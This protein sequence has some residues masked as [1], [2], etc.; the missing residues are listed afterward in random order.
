MLSASTSPA[1]EPT[2]E[3]QFFLGPPRPAGLEIENCR[4]DPR[5]ALP[6]ALA[7]RKRG[8]WIF[9][10]LE[11]G[12]GGCAAVVL[13]ENDDGWSRHDLSE[14]KRGG[15]LSG[16]SWHFVG[17]VGDEIWAVLD[18]NVESLGWQLLLV[19]SSDE[20]A[21][22]AGTRIKKV[23]YWAAFE[24]LRMSA[25]GIGRLTIRLDEAYPTEGTTFEPGLYHY[26][27]ANGGRSW[28]EAEWE[29]DD[30][31]PAS[32]DSA[33]RSESSLPKKT[34]QR[35]VEAVPEDIPPP[36]LGRLRTITWEKR[37]R[38]CAAT[39]FVD[40]DVPLDS[41]WRET[42]DGKDL[43]IRLRGL[44][45]EPSFF[46]REVGGTT[47]DEIIV[48]H[49]PWPADVVHLTLVPPDGV[50]LS[51]VVTLDGESSLRLDLSAK[52]GCQH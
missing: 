28:S 43:T 33:W 5:F 50:E 46:V 26:R 18:N 8:A 21:T 51:N 24:H 39:V 37:D 14:A 47:L 20:G 45:V 17:V 52:T 41:R 32:S 6:A 7:P 40:S 1:A 11:E 16:M 9:A 10:D 12:A 36:E 30:L 2:V 25:S 31:R 19:R 34:W 35:F 27:T 42:Q 13:V 4:V 38:E 29:P 48:S 23:S 15:E 22:W 44:M 3:L 49:Y